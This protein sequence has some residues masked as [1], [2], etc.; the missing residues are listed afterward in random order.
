MHIAGKKRLSIKIL[1]IAM[2]LYPVSAFFQIPQTLAQT[3][4][5]MIISPFRSTE[6]ELFINLE[7]L[8]ENMDPE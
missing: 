1:F 6:E 4:K 8:W 5:N 3:G 2:T 7:K